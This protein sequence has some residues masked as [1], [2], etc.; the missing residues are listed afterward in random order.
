MWKVQV[1][2]SL[3]LYVKSIFGICTRS[4]KNTLLAILGAVNIVNLVN[5]SLWKSAKNQNSEPLNVLKRQILHFCNPQNRVHVKSEWQ[6]N[7]KISTLWPA[8]KV[9]S[10]RENITGFTQFHDFFVIMGILN[11]GNLPFLQFLEALDVEFYDFMHFLK[12]EIYQIYHF[13]RL[14]II[15]IWY[16]SAFKKCIKS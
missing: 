1:F 13:Q 15:L 4:A 8:A 10:V 2:L 11:V 12:A 7:H 5:F 6:K 16:I 3:I 9:E 14:W